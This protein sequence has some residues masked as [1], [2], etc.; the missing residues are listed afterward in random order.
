MI[1]INIINPD[2]SIELV[3]RQNKH[4]I[5][6]Y[7]RESVYDVIPEEKQELASQHDKIDFLRVH[8]FCVDNL[9]FLSKEFQ[10]IRDN[11]S[12]IW[13]YYVA[14]K[15]PLNDVIQP[16]VDTSDFYKSK[17]HQMDSTIKS[18]QDTNKQIAKNAE[19][20]R[21]LTVIVFFSAIFFY[22]W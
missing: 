21:T 7:I 19:F 5:P 4:P 2:G 15:R 18:L 1:P 9:D 12:G 6:V 17:C 11:V 10:F 3:I 20:W 8:E 16:I 22:I 14:F 13:K